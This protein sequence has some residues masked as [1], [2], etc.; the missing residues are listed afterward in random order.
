MDSRRDVIKGEFT[1][2]KVVAAVLATAG[3]AGINVGYTGGNFDARR[4]FEHAHCRHKWITSDGFGDPDGLK[5]K[6]R[7]FSTKFLSLI[8]I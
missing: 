7:G 3:V 4:V 6:F 2:G 8:H 5:A 1:G